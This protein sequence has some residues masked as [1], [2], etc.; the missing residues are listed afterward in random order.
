M[1][2][3]RKNTMEALRINYL[4]PCPRNLCTARDLLVRWL[5]DA[6]RNN[7]DYKRY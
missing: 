6:K 4:A 7:E 2:T 5:R 3:T 1:R